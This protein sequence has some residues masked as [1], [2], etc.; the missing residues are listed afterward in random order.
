MEKVS[1]FYILIVISFGKSRCL[2]TFA[3]V[4]VLQAF[5]VSLMCRICESWCFFDTVVHA[6]ALSHYIMIHCSTFSVMLAIIMPY[7]CSF[8]V[9]SVNFN[10]CLFIVLLSQRKGSHYTLSYG[11]KN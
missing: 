8:L 4:S 6:V 3:S 2:A 11:N 10:L 1:L 7:F 5:S 9:N